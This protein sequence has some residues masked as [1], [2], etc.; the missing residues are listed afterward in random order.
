MNE[1]AILMSTYN[2]LKYLPEL[3]NS[4]YMQKFDA[5][6]KI[7]VRDDG[8][9]DGTLDYLESQERIGKITLIKGKNI[10]AK[11]SFLWLI[12][13]AKS[14]H[15]NYFALCDQDDI[16]QPQKIDR[17]VSLLNISRKKLYSSSV[18]L[19]DE[20]LNSIGTYVHKG[21]KNFVS[22]FFRNYVTG[23]TCVMHRDFLQDVEMPSNPDMIKMHDWWLAMIAAAK[24]VAV[25]D[26][27]SHILY[28]QHG[29]NVVGLQLGPLAFIKKSFKNIMGRMQSRDYKTANAISY[30]QVYQ[31]LDKFGGLP[32]ADDVKHSMDFVLTENSFLRRLKFTL[33]HLK[34]LGVVTALRFVFL[35]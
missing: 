4:I 15:H 24:D 6:I 8:S 19:V 26:I 12:T 31:F 18:E 32:N 16:W 11:E 34:D 22:T 30:A 25:Y 10:G 33:A 27:E 5:V 20:N 3:L 2:G 7:F 35:G 9:T 21:K 17:A 14:L 28:R 23:C 29:G 13:Y 1:V